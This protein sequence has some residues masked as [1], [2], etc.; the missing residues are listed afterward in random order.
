MKES[1]S[2]LLESQENS[3]PEITQSQPELIP[4]VQDIIEELI[5]ECIEVKL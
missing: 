2:Q 3:T 1:N 4:G 5:E